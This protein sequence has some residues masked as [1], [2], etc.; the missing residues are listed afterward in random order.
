MIRKK[1]LVSLLLVV[2]LGTVGLVGCGSTGQSAS[3]TP[4]ASTEDKQSGDLLSEIK[5]KGVIQIGTEGTY[6]PYTFH[7]EQD[8]LV[9]YDVEVAEAIAKELG[10]K[11]EF[12]ETPWDSCI[13]GLDAKRYDVVMNQVGI[14]PERTAKY[15]FSVPYTVTRAALI[16]SSENDNIKTFSDLKGKK[17]AQGLTSNYAKMAEENGA[18]LVDTDGQFSK[19]IDLITSDR[20]EATINDEVT[21]Y[22]YVHQKPDAKIKIADTL[23]EASENAVLI[24]KGNDSFVEAINKALE[25]LKNDG[26]LKAISEKYFGADVTK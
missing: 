6:A 8:K 5:S 4:D 24:R 12:V 26:T 10:V 18:E 15:D 20:A 1:N 25:K 9:G 22:D 13:A 14:T 3:K 21:F 19:S 2:I 17:T 16:V 23:S 7:N 11:A